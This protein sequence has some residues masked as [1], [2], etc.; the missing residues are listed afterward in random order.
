MNIYTPYTYL[1]GWSEHQIYYYGVRFA[2]KCH[3]TDLWKT[4]YT[5]SKYVKAFRKEHGEPDIIQIRKKFRC[6]E[7]AKLWEGAVLKKMN[8]KNRQDFLNVTD[9]NNIVSSAM[10][11]GLKA[12]WAKLDTKQRK[13]RSKN[14]V[15]AMQEKAKLPESRKK[16]SD[17]AKKRMDNMSKQDKVTHYGRMRKGLAHYHAQFSTDEK[18]QRAKHLVAMRKTV[19]CP[20]CNKIGST[21]NMNRWHL[22]NCKFRSV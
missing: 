17:I 4:Y 6:P 18:S 8:V 11:D 2:K 3:P 5:S 13:I 1:I 16:M 9:T 10:S 7:K 19:K 21:G 12:H 14:A 15:D 22:D 20:H